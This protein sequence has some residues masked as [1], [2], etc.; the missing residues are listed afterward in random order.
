MS[1]KGHKY[2]GWYVPALRLIRIDKI[3]GDNDPRF[4]FTVAHELGHFYLHNEL[5]PEVLDNAPEI[6]DSI[7]EI[8]IHRV[9]SSR[10]RSFI[11]RQANRFAAAVLIPRRTIIDAVIR[12]S[13]ILESA[14]VSELSGWT[15]KHAT[16]PLIGPSWECSVSSIEPLVPL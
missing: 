12:I 6:R 13:R 9:E 11:E 5:N 10:P 8:V 1:P 3:L 16:S 2:L 4:P 14:A 7:R 15:R